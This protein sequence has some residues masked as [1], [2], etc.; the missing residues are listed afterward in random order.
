MNAHVGSAHVLPP[1]SPA[2]SSSCRSCVSGAAAASM[3]S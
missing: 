2:A 3:L 1:S